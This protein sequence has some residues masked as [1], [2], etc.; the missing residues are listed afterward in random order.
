MMGYGFYHYVNRGVEIIVSLGEVDLSDN[1]VQVAVLGMGL[2]GVVL[3]VTSLF[4]LSG[5][6][7]ENKCCLTMVGLQKQL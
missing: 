1:V 5:A 3:F 4:G 6:I 7:L 2:L